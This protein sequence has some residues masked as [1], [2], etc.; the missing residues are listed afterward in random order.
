MSEVNYN[1]NLSDS[2]ANFADSPTVNHSTQS[3]SQ[4]QIQQSDLETATPQTEKVLETET[5]RTVHLTMDWQKVAHKLRE[6]NRKLLKQVFQLEQ[7]LA[8]VDNR[9]QK[10]LEQSKSSDLLI[11]RQATEIKDYQEK[12]ASM[13]Q[14]LETFQQETHSQQLTIESLSKQ[15]ELSQK[16]TA[17]LERECAALQEE[18]NAKTYELISTGKKAQELYNRLNRQQRYTLQYKA[19][20]A[21]HLNNLAPD[22]LNSETSTTSDLPKIQNQPIKAWSIPK[23]ESKIALPKTKPQLP[24]ANNRVLTPPLRESSSTKAASWPAP[25]IAPNSP[26]KKLQTLAAVELPSFP[27]QT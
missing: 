17:K 18:Y 19:A 26:N 2:Q 27:R 21:S 24:A 8:D 13:S 1:A 16:Q 5:D 6:Y 20:L 14:Q 25:A 22:E 10:N 11:A 12:I 9:F 3:A 4:P 7:N 15:L 23:S